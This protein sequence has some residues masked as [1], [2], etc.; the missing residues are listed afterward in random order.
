MMI[1]YIGLAT[2]QRLTT[3]LYS[4]YIICCFI[5]TYDVYNSLN[6][7]HTLILQVTNFKRTA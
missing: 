7:M 4:I 3:K 6:K 1:G 2:R 5:S